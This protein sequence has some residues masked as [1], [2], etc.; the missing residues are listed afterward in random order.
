MSLNVKEKEEQQKNN[1]VKL[2]WKEKKEELTKILSFW[3]K[4]KKE[5]ETL[6]DRFRKGKEDS[7]FLWKVL[8]MRISKR[9][10]LLYLLVNAEKNEKKFIRWLS[11]DERKILES[12]GRI[13]KDKFIKEYLY[14][15][16]FYGW[17][18]SKI[19]EKKIKIIDIVNQKWLDWIIEKR[20]EKIE[21][22]ISFDFSNLWDLVVKANRRIRTDS[23]WT[24]ELIE[25][26]NAR[27]QKMANERKSS[28]KPWIAVRL[29]GTFCWDDWV[30]IITDEWKDSLQP[31]MNISF[32]RDKITDKSFIYLVQQRK[33]KLKPWLHLNFCDNE[34]ITEKGAKV[35]ATEWKDCLE[36]WMRI[37]LQ[38]TNIWEQWV[39]AI[40]TEW[41]D[42]LKPWMSLNFSN[43]HMEDNWFKI[44]INEWSNSLQPWMQ[45]DLVHSS[46][47]PDWAKEM[48]TKLKLKEWVELNLYWN[49]FWDE[50][51]EAI[52][53]NME[54]KEWV[55]LDLWLNS[56]SEGMQKKLKE[57]EK[58]YHDKWIHCEVRTN[59]NCERKD[60]FTKK[61]IKKLWY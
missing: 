14:D 52:M 17:K 19:R 43:T 2:L 47:W 60:W 18:I 27:I 21:P 15:R 22:W 42:S 58:S 57:W 53:N 55:V 25:K 11:S 28:L 10:Q 5:W 30:M 34:Q 1:L 51:A 41:K 16:I 59:H 32:A 44:L 7:P 33:D 4:Y 48:A 3:E 37:N 6:K 45:L 12:M 46:F 39:E 20:K 49:H 8:N 35:L 50:W 40:V 13:T 31:W 38:Y 36:P 24:K 29:N 9:D 26:E 56:I 61:L 54:L 23:N